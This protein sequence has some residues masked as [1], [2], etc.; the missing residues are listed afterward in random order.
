MALGI[1]LSLLNTIISSI[2]DNLHHLNNVK[3]D[4]SLFI[5]SV[6]IDNHRLLFKVLD[7]D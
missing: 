2:R 1:N 5:T 3:P 6:A 7:F 4:N